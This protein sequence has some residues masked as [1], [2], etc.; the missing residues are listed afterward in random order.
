MHE[1]N[2]Y[3]SVGS[4]DYMGDDGVSMESDHTDAALFFMKLKLLRVYC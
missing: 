2:W 1:S 4:A 3:F